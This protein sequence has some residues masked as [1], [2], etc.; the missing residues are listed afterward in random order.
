MFTQSSAMRSV[1]CRLLFC[2][3]SRDGAVYKRMLKQPFLGFAKT[4]RPRSSLPSAG[5]QLQRD[6]QRRA[7]PLQLRSS[8]ETEVTQLESCREPGGDR[9]RDRGTPRAGAQTTRQLPKTSWQA[10]K[11]PQRHS[12][13][14]LTRAPQ[15]VA[16]TKR[17]RTAPQRER[18]DTHDHRTGFTELKTDL[19]S[20]TARAPSSRQIRTT[21]Q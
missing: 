20:A 8:R 10:A 9:T 12:E 19:H 5:R 4:R 2:S 14:D 13:S 17:I 7:F 21:P 1:V 16:R 3:G 15:R 11:F 6:S 18:S